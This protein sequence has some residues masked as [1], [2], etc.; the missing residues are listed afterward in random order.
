MNMKKLLKSLL[1]IAAAFLMVFS[2][3]TAVNADYDSSKTATITVTDTSGVAGSTFKAYQILQ[4]SNSGTNY[5]YYVPQTY[6]SLLQN[7]LY[8]ADSTK[9]PVKSSITDEQIIDYIDHLDDDKTTADTNTRAFAEAVYAKIL[10]TTIAPTTS[11]TSSL[12]NEKA[13]VSFTVPQGYY[14]IAEEGATGSDNTDSLVMLN[15]NGKNGNINITTKEKA[16]TVEKKVQEH[17]DSNQNSGVNSEYQDAADWDI[18]DHVPLQLKGTVSDRID[19]YSTYYYKFADKLSNGLTFDEN[20]LH[21]F[22]NNRGTE[23]EVKNVTDNSVTD[24]TAGYVIKNSDTDSYTVNNGYAPNLVVEFQDLKSVKDTK[25]NKISVNANSVVYVRYTAT[26]NTN[27]VIGNSGNP[28]DVVLRFE[29]NPYYNG[30][31]THT[32]GETPKDEVVV[33]TYRTV[34]NKTKADGTTALAGADFTLKKLVKDADGKDTWVEVGSTGNPGVKETNVVSTTTQFAFKGLD[35]GT[36]QLT[37][38][39]TPDGYKTMSPVQFTI[40]ATRADNEGKDNEGMDHTVTG[41][42]MLTGLSGANITS[43]T[44]DLGTFT[45]DTTNNAT[46]YGT[47]KANV[48][49]ESGSSLPSTGGI[50]TTMFYVVGGGLVAVAAALLISKKRASAE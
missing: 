36:Y 3:G 39:K 42:T 15:T 18:N 25:G 29:N 32:P 48:K 12:D 44:V 46:N 33:F 35:A 10:N 7:V 2:L 24:K 1:A 40:T 45:L 41:N 23:T 9:Y 49:N 50:G 13:Q 28:N 43:G 22:I 17:D 21:V 16:P 27:A 14:L 30:R 11:G 20:S 26:L 34:F 31:G 6:R 8:D 37:E 19:N 47:L 4:L 38:S 5:T